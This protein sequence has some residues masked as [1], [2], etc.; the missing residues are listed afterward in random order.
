MTSKAKLISL[1]DLD[2]YYHEEPKSNRTA[3]RV[4]EAE[5]SKKS[6][7]ISLVAEET[8]AGQVILIEK[9]KYFAALK[10]TKSDLR[11]PCLV[12]PGRSDKERILHILKVSIP[13][14]KNTSWLFYNKHVVML[15]EDHNMS[16]DEIAGLV[17][18]DI[19]KIKN[20]TL[21]ESIPSNIREIAVEMKAR[22]VVQNICSSTVIPE[23]MKIILYEKSVLNKDHIHR[24]TSEKLKSI[25]M[26]CAT[27]LPF[28]LLYDAH[29]LEQLIDEL[30]A[31]NFNL[32]DHMK[33]LM[34][35][36]MKSNSNKFFQPL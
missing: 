26:L 2:T 6:R 23:E 25:K 36:Y 3:E 17:N 11:V 24:L 18:C 14:E 34:S 13:L 22:T 33:S 29:E 31:T 30:L 16:I 35:S 1:R 21:D 20:Y 5:N 7:I 12:Y 27:V 4:I 32:E 28:F 19:S 10:K 15:L 8:G 9:F